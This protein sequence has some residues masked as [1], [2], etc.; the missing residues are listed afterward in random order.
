[1]RNFKRMERRRVAFKIGVVYQTSQE[2]LEA[3]PQL[4]REIIE[5]IELA[6]FDRAH[7]AAYGDFS[8]NFEIVY[9]VLSADYNVY[10]DTQQKINLEIRKAFAERNIEF[11]Y[12][13]QTVLLQH[14]RGESNGYRLHAERASE[15]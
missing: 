10:M 4:I 8:L 14:E 7:F 2:N 12:P 11:A 3:I 13:T 5:D 6:E 9:Y 1:M 15:N